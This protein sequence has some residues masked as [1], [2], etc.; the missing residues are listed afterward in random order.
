MSSRRWPSG[1]LA[2]RP[3]ASWAAT[4]CTFAGGS[5][6]RAW[7]AGLEPEAGINAT[8]EAAHQ[9]LAAAAIARPEIGTTVTPTVVQSGTTV[10]TVPASATVSVDVRAETSAELRRVEDALASLT[11]V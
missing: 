10:N 4:G 7:H 3:S 6:S 5:G 8:L 9:V 11:P 2:S 1:V